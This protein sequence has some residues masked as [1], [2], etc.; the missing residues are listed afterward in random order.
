MENVFWI[1]VYPGLGDQQIDFM[2]EVLHDTCK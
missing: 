1:G 2:L